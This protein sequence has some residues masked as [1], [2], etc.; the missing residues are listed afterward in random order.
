VDGLKKLGERV[1]QVSGSSRDSVGGSEK[2]GEWRVLGGGGAGLCLGCMHSGRCSFKNV[3]MIIMMCGHHFIIYP[4]PINIL[5]TL[6]AKCEIERITFRCVGAVFENISF[7]NTQN[8]ATFIEK[9]LH[10]SVV[11]LPSGHQYSI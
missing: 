3:S 6:N 4:I 7:T 5:N 8:T 9:Q 10:I 2:L 11:W 1:K